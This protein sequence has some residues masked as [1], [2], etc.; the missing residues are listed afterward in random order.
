MVDAFYR[1]DGDVGQVF[2]GWRKRSRGEAATAW[3]C[4]HRAHARRDNPR[5]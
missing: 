3:V 5:R 1:I 2:D 4:E